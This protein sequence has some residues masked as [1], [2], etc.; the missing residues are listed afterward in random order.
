[1]PTDMLDRVSE[2]LLVVGAPRSGTTWVGRVLEQTENVTFVGEPDSEHK[3]PFA[4]EAK[5]GLGTF[6]LLVPGDRAPAYE[7]LW[8]RALSGHLRSRSLDQRAAGRFL[9]N[10]ELSRVH[11][12]IDIHDPRLTPRLRLV[13]LL[14]RTPST[15]HPGR[16]A[17]VKSVFVA[18][19]LD[20]LLSTFPEVETLIV[21]RNPLNVLASWV[22][23]GFTPY[24]FHQDRRLRELVLEPL[25][26]P[27]YPAGA[28]PVEAM[29]WQVGVLQAV[30]TDVAERRPEIKVV[31][32]EEL[33]V[34]PES[35]Y[36]ELSARVGLVW[37][38]KTQDFLMQSNVP[39]TGYEPKRDLQQQQ[40]PD[41]WKKRLTEQ[42]VEEI[43]GVL[44]RFPRSLV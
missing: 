2:S 11:E 31:R 42:Q 8:A 4:L 39:G 23:L 25:D 44:S 20:W 1:M 30:L 19:C 7:T 33:V 29:A 9:R 28:S 21:E 27:Q 14:A 13:R 10:E 32:H 6:P 22:A 3:E 38:D 36:K 37:T 12:A 24:S 41:R 34:D 35:A 26:L 40:D 16:R 15:Q 43:T 17:V 18:L 5:H